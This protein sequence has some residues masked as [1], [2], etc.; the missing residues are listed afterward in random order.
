MVAPRVLVARLGPRG[1]DPKLDDGA[2]AIRTIRE[3]AAEAWAGEVPPDGFGDK[4]L[5]QIELLA[6]NAIRTS[7]VWEACLGECGKPRALTF[8]C[9][10]DWSLPTPAAR[11]RELSNL[12]REK[13]PS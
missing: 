3:L 4:T 11:L 10:T 12:Q 6:S 8:L 9:I 1:I 7:H 5:G 13:N 2:E